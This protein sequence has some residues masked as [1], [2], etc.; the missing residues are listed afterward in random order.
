MLLCMDDLSRKYPDSTRLSQDSCNQSQVC[1]DLGKREETSGQLD[2][3]FW[4]PIWAPSS[5]GWGTSDKSY[6]LSGEGDYVLRPAL[7][8]TVRTKC[9]RSVRKLQLV[10][11][12][13]D[14]YKQP[15]WQNP[16]PKSH[17]LPSAG[18]V[19]KLYQ[20]RIVSKHKYQCLRAVNQS[21]AFI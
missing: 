8:G 17:P 1:G 3:S 14:N 20:E 18:Q 9:P 6:E 7:Q 19:D 12:F 11:L 13:Q 21:R 5:L 2:L 16:H 10:L 4:A 15:E